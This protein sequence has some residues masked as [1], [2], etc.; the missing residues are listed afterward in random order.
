MLEDEV[1]SL[2]AMFSGTS[3]IT[4][5]HLSSLLVLEGTGRRSPVTNVERVCSYAD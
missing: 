1:G 5:L 4:L 2:A 3:S